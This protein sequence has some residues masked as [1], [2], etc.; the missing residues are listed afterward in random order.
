MGRVGSVQ[1][2][3]RDADS[4]HGPRHRPDRAM[5]GSRSG[6]GRQQAGEAG[7]TGAHRLSAGIQEKDNRAIFRAE[8]D[9]VRPRHAAL[10]HG[11]A[12]AGQ[13]QK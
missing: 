8:G 4:R 7:V 2:L 10:R 9:S 11:L 12:E 5:A 1:D 13:G 6:E 3:R